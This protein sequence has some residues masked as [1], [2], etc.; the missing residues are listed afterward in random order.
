M[1]KIPPFKLEK[2]PLSVESKNLPGFKW[3]DENIGSRNKLGG[4]PDFIQGE[5]VPI[6]ED[7][8]KR[9]TFYAQ[10]DSINDEYCIADCGMIY[11]FMCFECNNVKSI[12]QSN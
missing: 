11:V 3:A 10:L 1:K 6:C 2:I 4:E 9:M 7:C 12:I 8:K 5:D